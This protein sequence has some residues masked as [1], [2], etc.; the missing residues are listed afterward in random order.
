MTL[1]HHDEG[2]SDQ[3]DPFLWLEGEEGDE[4]AFR[5]RVLIGGSVFVVLCLGIAAGLRWWA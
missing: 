2:C 4:R 3:S 5:T 1:Q